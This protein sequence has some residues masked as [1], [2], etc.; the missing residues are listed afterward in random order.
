LKKLSKRSKI[1][2]HQKE[3]TFSIKSCAELEHDIDKKKRQAK[4]EHV[5]FWIW[6]RNEQENP[7]INI[8]ET[9]SGKSWEKRNNSDK[10][11]HKGSKSE[12][13]CRT[14]ASRPES[15]S[16]TNILKSESECIQT[17]PNLSLTIK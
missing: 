15:D 3:D 12:P 5:W 2:F 17:F 14:H 13:D 4:N 16:R 9:L 8:S 7:S 6:I 1:S 11:S 10:M